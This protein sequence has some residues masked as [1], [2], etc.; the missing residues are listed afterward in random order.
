MF[1]R[2]RLNSFKVFLHD[3]ADFR[4]AQILLRRHGHHQPAG[5]VFSQPGDLVREPGHVLLADIGQHQIDQIGSR[6]GRRSFGRAGDA[7]RI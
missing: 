5:N 3:R 6:R 7:G 1:R 2:H 4:I